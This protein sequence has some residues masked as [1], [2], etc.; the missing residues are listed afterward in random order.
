MNNPGSDLPSNPGQTFPSN[1]ERL[2]RCFPG[3]SNGEFG[4]PHDLVPVLRRGRGCRVE[5]AGGRSYLDMTMAWGAALIG[6]AHPQVVEAVRR[7]AESGGNF[8][9][10]NERSLELAERL[11]SLVPCAERVR[12]V[13]SGTEATMLCLRL[14]RGATQRSK[15]LRFEGAYHGQHPEGVA[16][17][18]RGRAGDLPHVDPTGAGSDDVKTSTLLA[19]FNDLETTARIIT[20][21]A[22]DLAA[23]IVEPLHRCLPPESGFLA[24][25]RKLTRRFGVVLIFDEVVTGFR[26]A[27]GGAQERY[28][29]IPDLAAWGKA[30][31]GGFPIGAYGGRA[32]LMD[33]INE[34]RLDKPDYVWSASTG[35]GNPVSCAAALATLDVLSESGVYR[36][37]FDSGERLRQLM[38]DVF[39]RRS[40]QVQI[41]G[42]GPLAQFVFSPEP[43]KDF[44]GWSKAD[45]ARARLLMHELVRQGVFLNPMGTKLYIS[46]GHDEGALEEF[47]GRLDIALAKIR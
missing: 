31:G 47:A 13:A 5:D 2:L 33:T 11:I 14:A 15:I 8:A 9:A 43:V 20:E 12:F 34:H 1:E 39:A 28:G 21:N 41:L 23:V 36:R 18:L 26:L 30:L 37:L 10:I 45:R 35:G 29:A 6:H 7:Q 46:L 4:L 22:E 16:G 25:L 44:Q 42:D 19:P 40:E 24:G 17:M 32:D 27:L 38:R 3:A